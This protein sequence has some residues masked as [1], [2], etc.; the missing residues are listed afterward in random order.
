MSATN[1]PSTGDI[2]LRGL[3]R[4]DLPV[5]YEWYQ[6]RSVIDTLVGGFRFRGRDEAVR[7]MERWLESSATATRLMITDGAD[8]RLGVAI[9]DGIDMAVRSA[10]LSIFIAAAEP[11]GRGLGQATVRLLLDYA[12][13]DIGLNRVHLHV[14]STNEAA[15]NTYLKC[16][17]VVEGKLREAAFK[18][19]GFVDVLAMAVLAGDYRRGQ[20]AGA[21]ATT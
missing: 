2:R 14:L 16:G 6:R 3:T 5:L 8:Q 13:L 1:R 20:A 18:Q 4:E 19:G 15:I 21:S 11:R 10:E 12:F 17:F 7:Y 9:L